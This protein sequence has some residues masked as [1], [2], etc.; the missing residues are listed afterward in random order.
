[1]KIGII[2]CGWL[3][4][5]LGRFLGI[6]HDIFATTTSFEKLNTLN[7]ENFY[8]YVV[9]FDQIICQEWEIISDLDVIII[10]IPFGKSLEIDFLTQRL[11]NLLKFIG[12]FKKQMFFTSSIGIYSSVEGEISEDVPTDLL[13]PNLLFV[14]DSLCSAFPQINIL[15]LGGLM[16]DNRKLSNYSVANPQQVVNHIHYQDVASV[17]AKMIRLHLHSKKYNVVAPQHPVKQEIIN[18]QKGIA[19]A[20]HYGKPSGKIV[21]SQ[22]LITELSYDFLFPNPLF[23]N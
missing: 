3:G 11:Q 4:I 7:F 5:R 21:S 14:E 2:G 18:F 17:I 19:K 20:T 13:H 10:S 1:M 15:R 22:R 6:H 23:F 9:D 12:K 8:P 16:G